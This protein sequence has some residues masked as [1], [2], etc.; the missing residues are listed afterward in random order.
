MSPVLNSWLRTLRMGRSLVLRIGLCAAT[1]AVTGLAIYGLGEKQ[2]Q[3]RAPTVAKAVVQLPLAASPRIAAKRTADG[4][5]FSPSAVREELIADANLARALAHKGGAGDSSHVESRVA[6]TVA[7]LRW[8]ALGLQ[9]SV[10]EDSPSGTYR[11]SFAYAGLD[12]EF[13]ARLVNA[14]AEQY[15]KDCRDRLQQGVREAA[16]EAHRASE[17][18]KGVFA[19][20]KSE[21]DALLEVRFQA[22]KVASPPAGSD[23]GAAAL[24]GR[25]PG[26]SPSRAVKPASARTM[27]DNPEWIER[28][29]ELEGLQRRR[30]ALLADRT[31]LHPEVQELDL[32]IARLGRGLE[33]IP[34]K[35]E[36]R[37]APPLSEPEPETSE[38][39]PLHT[40]ESADRDVAAGPGGL[41][42]DAEMLRAFHAQRQRLQDAAEEVERLVGQEREAT[43]AVLRLPQIEVRRANGPETAT[44]SGSSVRW[45]WAALLAALGAAAGVGLISHGTAIDPPLR[46]PA[47]VKASLPIPLVATISADAS[48][49][50]AQGPGAWTADRSLW[51]VLGMLVIVVC[52]LVVLR[53]GGWI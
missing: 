37:T 14:L 40:R 6:G 13:S 7:D 53:L 29:R 35:V 12:P 50:P 15:A 26:R 8:I 16:E 34:R 21:F 17:R 18:A 28:N 52:T 31:P 20:L 46:S 44:A 25:V 2:T 39:P 43:E 45:P 5:P 9:V 38:P 42:G 24:P 32:R 22:Q 4:T 36:D 49:R 41:P 19:R 33:G 27:V 1:F 47:E 51:I 23:P 3:G 48:D 30:S 11:V 10:D